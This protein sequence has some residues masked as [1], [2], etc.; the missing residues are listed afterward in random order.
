MMKKITL[1]S[2]FLALLATFSARAQENTYNMVI[3][4]TNGTKINIGPND[5]RS[6][7]FNDGQLVVTGGDLQAWMEMVENDIKATKAALADTRYNQDAQQASIYAI[8]EQMEVHQNAIITGGDRTT[9]L[10]EK[11]AQIEDMAIENLH[12][13]MQQEE[14][15]TILE[16]KIAM[17]EEEIKQ[18][19]G[20]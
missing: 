9:C 15:I 2:L 7:T 10:E 20:E 1:V 17:L 5:I 8:Q 4:M 6:L 11:T 16:A 3:E 13:N 14:K 19:K 18:L 12:M